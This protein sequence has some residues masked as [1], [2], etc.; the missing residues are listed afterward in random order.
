MKIMTEVGDLV[1]RSG[2]GRTCRVLGSRTIKRLGGAVCG[3]HRAHGDEEHVFLDSA[4]K[5]RSTICLDSKPLGQFMSVLA[6]NH[7]NGFSSVW[8]SK[9]MAMVCQWFDLKTPE[10]VFSV[11]TSKSVATVSSGL[12]S[13]SV[14]CFLVKPQNQGGVGFPSL[15]LKTD[16]CGLVIWASKLPRWFL[17]LCLKTKWA[18][19]YRL[20]YKT[21]GGISARDTRRVL[22]ACFA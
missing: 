7:S 19:V 21:D 5:S 6:Q 15:S 18:S 1:Q 22:A 13:K 14:L 20:R 17:G 2:D 3:L 10:T 4:S 9:P 8:S 16:G 12:A 11:L